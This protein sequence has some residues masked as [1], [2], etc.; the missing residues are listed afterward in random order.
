M[1]WRR[2][3]H[4]IAGSVKRHF[5]VKPLAFFMDRETFRD[6]IGSSDKLRFLRDALSGRKI[7]SKALPIKYRILFFAAGVWAVIWQQADVDG[8]LH[9][10]LT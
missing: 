9:E 4:Q 8:L 1:D 6:L 10:N 7:M 2:E 5:G 3:Y